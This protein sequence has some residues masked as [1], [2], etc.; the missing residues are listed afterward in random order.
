MSR[1]RSVPAFIVE[2]SAP[3][4]KGTASAKATNES[5]GKP[6]SFVDAWSPPELTSSSSIGNSRGKMTAAGWRLVRTT[7]RSASAPTCSAT[8]LTSSVS[9]R[10]PD[11]VACALERAARL[12]QEDVVERRRLDLEARERE[13]RVV[14][15]A[16]DR[17]QPG[18]PSFSRTATS[19]V[20]PP[21]EPPKRASDV[22]EPPAVRFVDRDGV[23]ARQPD[24]RLQRGRRALGDD[25]CRGR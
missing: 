9:G 6:G 17:G 4:M 22:R 25:P 8:V 5:V 10:R 3:W 15:G 11:V 19:R 12:G 16:D 14:D 1:A 2:K 23:D 7:E 21:S 13:A 24:L 20:P 18:E